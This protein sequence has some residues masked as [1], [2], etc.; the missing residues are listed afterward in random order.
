MCVHSPFVPVIAPFTAKWDWPFA[1]QA[2]RL[3]LSVETDDGSICA[4]QMEDTI[5]PEYSTLHP[6]SKV[7]EKH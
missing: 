1:D 6:R 7:F 2:D 4:N 5:E 3:P